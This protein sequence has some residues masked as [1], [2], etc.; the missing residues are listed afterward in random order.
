MARKK[1]QTISNKEIS[2]YSKKKIW[3]SPS[4]I[5]ENLGLTL[6]E[7]K[8]W[9]LSEKCPF[10]YGYIGQDEKFHTKVLKLQFEEWLENNKNYI[11]K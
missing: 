1:G 4:Y 3:I 11:V 9:L 6:E 8:Q 2:P 7:T 10:G 5:A